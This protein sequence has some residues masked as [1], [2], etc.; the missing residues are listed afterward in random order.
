MQ[1][2]AHKVS[3]AVTFVPAAYD[4]NVQ[5]A[6]SNVKQRTIILSWIRQLFNRKISKYKAPIPVTEVRGVNTMFPDP[7]VCQPYSR[8]TVRWVGF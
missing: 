6:L 8:Q 3:S 4:P 5:S 2:D 7:L 1:Q